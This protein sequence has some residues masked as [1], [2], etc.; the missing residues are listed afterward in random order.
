MKAFQFNTTPGIRFGSD[1]SVG[2]AEEVSKKLG[3]KI[4]FVTD[5][6]LVKIG[7]HEKTVTELQ[8]YFISPQNLSK[9]EADVLLLQWKDTFSTLVNSNVDRL[10]KD[11][12]KI[13]FLSLASYSIPELE[14]DANELWSK[15]LEGVEY[16]HKFSIKDVPYPLNTISK[17]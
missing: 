17:N 15:L 4:L 16:C 5:P 10:S 14:K 11:S 2:T 8:K 1:Y 12:F 3:N 9:K 13:W 6:G 7:L